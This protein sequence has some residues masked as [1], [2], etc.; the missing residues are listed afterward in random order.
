MS[1]SQAF[2]IAITVV[3]LGLVELLS[4]SELEEAEEFTA[5]PVFL[6]HVIFG[7][8]YGCL[9]F[10]FAMTI[11]TN[12]AP[13]PAW[14]WPTA[15]YGGWIF[16][17]SFLANLLVAVAKDN[18]RLLR[19]VFMGIALVIYALGVL[20][21][22]SGYQKSLAANKRQDAIATKA[23]IVA[24]MGRIPKTAYLINSKGKKVSLR[25]SFKSCLLQTASGGWVLRVGDLKACT[26]HPLPISG[27]LFRSYESQL[28]LL[29]H[30]ND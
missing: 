12:Y 5:A 28:K 20:L 7:L 9:I 26:P 2:F 11:N 13:L 17:A 29:T 16:G 30:T 15:V 6:F 1:T 10:G 19:K 18:T 24:A 23:Q 21:P 14:F 25:A 3:I 4:I 8:V 22:Y 27:K